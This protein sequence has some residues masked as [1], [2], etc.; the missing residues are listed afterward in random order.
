M[1]K[2]LPLIACLAVIAVLIY[3]LHQIQKPIPIAIQNCSNDVQKDITSKTNSSEVFF[4]LIPGIRKM[5]NDKSV[6]EFKI[7]RTIDL[8]RACWR[9]KC[10]DIVRLYS[11]DVMEAIVLENSLINFFR[12]HYK[13][14]NVVN[15]SGGGI[16]FE[17]INHVYIEFKYA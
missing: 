10:D 12:S 5:I 13:N 16:C 17:K 3:I 1:K 15:G 4:D 7:G 2:I 8:P 9:F 14:K 6:K 11:S